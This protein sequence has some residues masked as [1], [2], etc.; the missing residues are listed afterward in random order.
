M[1]RSTIGCSCLMFLAMVGSAL[2]AEQ[3]PPGTHEKKLS[4]G[5]LARTYRVHIPPGYDGSK[6]VPLVLAFHGKGGTDATV[7]KR[8]GFD[9]VADRHNFIVA[10]PQGVNDYWNDGRPA[11][12]FPNAEQIDDVGFVSELISKCL[13]VEFRIDPSRI[14][15]TGFS[16]GGFFT[17]RLGWELSDKLAAIAPVAGTMGVERARNFFP[18]G[19][20]SVIEIHGTLDEIVKYEGGLV[21]TTGA[22]AISAPEM[23]AMWAKADGCGPMPVVEFNP[24]NFPGD[25]SRTRHEI[26]SAGR[27]GTEVVLVTMEG[28]EHNWPQARTVSYGARQE[29]G[30]MNAAAVMIW[31]FFER[32]PKK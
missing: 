21:G 2:A 25:R 12:R 16:N 9:P 6:P 26:Y 7:E 20:V 15:A 14:Y 24:D 32:H 5:G 18:K 4:Y 10:Y 23:A 17:Q 3:L 11:P 8:L 28:L 1:N 29:D 19:P 30:G 27:A 13:T 31:K 22:M